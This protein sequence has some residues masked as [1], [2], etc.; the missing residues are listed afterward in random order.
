MA[1]AIKLNSNEQT[2]YDRL[3]QLVDEIHEFNLNRT[4][5]RGV[6]EERYKEMKQKAH[7]LHMALKGGGHEP[8]HHAY[9]YK[10][11]GVPVE[12]IE[13]Y[14]HVHPVED[15]LA[16]I[17]DPDAN[18]DPEDSTMGEEFKVRIYT[19][20]W[21]HYDVY[22]LTRIQDG[23][24]IQGA[25][26]FNNNAADESGKPALFAALDHDSV[27]YPKQTEELLEHI[28]NKAKMGATR[29]QIQNYLDDLAKW[30]S[31]CEKATPAVMYE[32]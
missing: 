24:D 18:K 17:N 28:W 11:R 20:R 16:F 29:E 7:D 25:S 26:A 3:R 23:W 4:S 15:L 14:D 13:F 32:S 8:K 27:C 1:E 5:D 21:G 30:I 31:I 19:N 9:M 22:A 2:L 12:N 6:Q 10:N